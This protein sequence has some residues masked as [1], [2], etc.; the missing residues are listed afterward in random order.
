[1]SP[2]VASVENRVKKIKTVLCRECRSFSSPSLYRALKLACPWD[3][4]GLSY[5]GTIK[6][7]MG[8]GSMEETVGILI[9]TMF[10]AV[11]QP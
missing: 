2:P 4:D 9:P 11:S 3:I 5:E 10:K 8:E 6:I 7:D 1:M